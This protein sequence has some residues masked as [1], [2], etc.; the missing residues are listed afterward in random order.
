MFLDEQ[1]QNDN[2]NK[3]Q[4]P[5]PPTR[6]KSDAESVCHRNQKPEILKLDNPGPDL[7][8]PFKPV[9]PQI[10]HPRDSFEH[11]GFLGNRQSGLWVRKGLCGRFADSGRDGD[12]RVYSFEVSGFEGSYRDLNYYYQD[13][14]VGS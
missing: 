4:S 6:A 13:Y 12:S 10:V 8:N 11:P 3:E 2:V 14:L 9:D 1:S 5:A 7:Q